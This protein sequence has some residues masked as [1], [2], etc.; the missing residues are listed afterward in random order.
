M[1]LYKDPE[2]LS[3]ANTRRV[4]FRLQIFRNYVENLIGY[5]IL[6]TELDYL[7]SFKNESKRYGASREASLPLARKCVF[8]R[9]QNNA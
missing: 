7:F 8:S 1:V 4:E 5:L 9:S 6:K 3:N 2:I